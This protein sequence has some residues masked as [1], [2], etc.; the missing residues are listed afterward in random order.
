MVPYERC[1]P[2]TANTKQERTGSLSG[3]AD[4]VALAR[5]AG[6]TKCAWTADEE[7]FD[8]LIDAALT[9][10]GPMFIAA[11]IDDKPGVGTTDRDPVQIRQRFMMGLGVRKT[12]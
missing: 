12:L 6:L 7:D 10:G 2:P 5:A 3:T 11:R 4:Y 9:D 8:R 1:G